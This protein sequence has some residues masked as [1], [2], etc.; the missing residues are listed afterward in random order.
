MASVFSQFAYCLFANQD[1]LAEN[2]AEQFEDLELA[3]KDKA[4]IQAKED[5]FALDQAN[6]R[7]NLD[8]DVPEF[9]PTPRPDTVFSWFHSDGR[10]KQKVQMCVDEQWTK[11][12]LMDRNMYVKIELEEVEGEVQIRHRVTKELI[13]VEWVKS[14][15]DL[16][17]TMMQVSS[18]LM[19]YITLAP[20]DSQP[21]T[22]N[23]LKLPTGSLSPAGHPAPVPD[24]SR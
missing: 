23:R 4:E 6:G 21:H 5:K 7:E 20:R 1:I 9:M 14:K 10:F 18:Q 3:D 19:F 24:H 13:K 2:K 22:S 17:T 8:A 12:T 16:P 15:D 11:F